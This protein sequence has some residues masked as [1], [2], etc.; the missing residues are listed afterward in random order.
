[1]KVSGWVL[2]G[3][4]LAGAAPG[5]EDV[6]LLKNSSFE[7]PLDPE[8]WACDQPAQWIRWGSWMNR[9]TGWAPTHSG[10]C[11]MG[12]HHFRLRGE[13]NAG[14]YQDVRDARAAGSYSF[15]VFAWVDKE[16][17]AENITLQLHSYHG[18]SIVASA[19][20][21]LNKLDRDRWIPLSVTGSPPREGL[22]VMLIVTPKT[23]GKFCKGAIKFDDASLGASK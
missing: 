3:L 23:G 4:L 15:Q 9:E 18:G 13:D 14:I 10:N 17:N 8:N 12:F 19:E 2:V 1:M 16:A 11:L 6:S 22:R 5:Q 20:Y 21:R 7:I